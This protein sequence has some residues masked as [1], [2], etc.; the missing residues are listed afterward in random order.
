MNKEK[1]RRERQAAGKPTRRK[2]IK[3]VDDDDTR[4]EVSVSQS[5]TDGENEAEILNSFSQGDLD[6]KKGKDEFRRGINRETGLNPSSIMTKLDQQIKER[7]GKR[8]ELKILETRND[9]K[10]RR[11][12]LIIRRFLKMSV[13]KLEIADER[14]TML[15]Y[16]NLFDE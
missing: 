12:L 5:E 8:H 15:R 7:R 4:S 1:I 14:S 11:Q 10:V 2:L 16:D 9:I 13:E 6:K 3:K